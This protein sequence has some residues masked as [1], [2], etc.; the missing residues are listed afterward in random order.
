MRGLLHHDVGELV[1]IGEPPLRLHRDLEC[2]RLLDR[3]RV[4]DAGGDLDVLRL[5][6]QRHVVR[7]HAQRLQP[8]GIEP[9]PHRIVAA[10]EHRDRADAVDAGE[11]I[12]DLERRV[13]RDEQ[14]VARIVGRDQ[15]HDHH[16]V[17][18]GLG[19]GH[20]DSAHVG[21]QARLRDADAV[22]HLH[23]RDIQVGAD[24]E[25]DRDGEASVGGRIRRHVEHV[26][27][28]VDL[29]LDRSDHGGGDDLGV[30]AGVLPGDVDD[31]RRDLRILRDRQADERHAAEDD[32]HD[33]Q[34]RGEDRPVDEEM[35]DFHQRVSLS[36]DNNLSNA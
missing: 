27:H 2:A 7:R 18:R 4:E 14:G 6:R 1:R 34:H 26:L 20:A 3:R 13:V 35:G 9:D 12:L 19:D 17:G 5:Q 29:L 33:R 8:A 16:Q 10:A 31:R 28:A 36:I 11:R 24:I 22:L 25:R 23:L 15:V 30:G 32:E 21:R